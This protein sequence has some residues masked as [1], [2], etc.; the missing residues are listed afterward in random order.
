M[1]IPKINE[2]KVIKRSFKNFTTD[3]WNEAL[4]SKDWPLVKIEDEKKSDLD[5]MVKIF[6]ENIEEALNEIDVK[7]LVPLFIKSMPIV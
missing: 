2:K 4:A 6:Q 5:E 1:Y 3:K 7:P